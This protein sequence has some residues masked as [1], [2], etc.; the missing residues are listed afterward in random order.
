LEETGI[1]IRVFASADTADWTSNRM[2]RLA[3]RTV[4]GVVFGPFSALGD[5]SFITHD[6]REL[7]VE[8][9]APKI[10]HSIMLLTCPLVFF[11]CVFGT[12]QTFKRYKAH[13]HQS[14]SSSVSKARMNSALMILTDVLVNT[15]RFRNS[16]QMRKLKILGR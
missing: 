1:Y 14:H 11:A 16:M 13:P 15:I 12:H 3:V 7:Q 4:K 9:V 8:V 2:R 10:F 6:F 5:L